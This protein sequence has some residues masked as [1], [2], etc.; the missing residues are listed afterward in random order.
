MV[1]QR[2]TSGVNRLNQVFYSHYHDAQKGSQDAVK[3]ITRLKLD[4][5]SSIREVDC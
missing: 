2:I 4:K 5:G 3:V 1:T